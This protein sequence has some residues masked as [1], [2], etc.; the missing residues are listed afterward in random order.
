MFIRE[1]SGFIPKEGKQANLGRENYSCHTANT[2]RSSR[3]GRAHQS[4]PSV[5]VGPYFFS[6]PPS[7]SV[8]PWGGGGLGEVT[9]AEAISEGTKG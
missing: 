4:C 9:A 6:V 1:C 7:L 8:V 2:I 5:P 3:D